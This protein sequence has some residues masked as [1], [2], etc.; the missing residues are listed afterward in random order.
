MHPR[1]STY[2][3]V[4][5]R[6]AGLG[7]GRPRAEPSRQGLLLG[8]TSTMKVPIADRNAEAASDIYRF[9]NRVP[10]VAVAVVYGRV[11]RRATFA[12]ARQFNGYRILRPFLGAVLMRIVYF[13]CVVPMLFCVGVFIYFWPSW[14]WPVALTVMIVYG[15]SATLPPT[16]FPALARAATRRSVA[17]AG[18]PVTGRS[19]RPDR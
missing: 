5:R 18:K 9:R 19:R 1:R 17:E 8:D 10:L 6:V 14:S 2:E 16:W 11:T 13:V 4:T 7:T 12:I 15:L 3:G